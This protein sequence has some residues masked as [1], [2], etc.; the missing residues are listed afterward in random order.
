V[1]EK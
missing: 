1:G